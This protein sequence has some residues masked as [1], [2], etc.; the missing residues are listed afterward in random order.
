MEKKLLKREMIYYSNGIDD[1]GDEYAGKTGIEEYTYACPCGN[2][3]I[4]EEHDDTPGY[5]NHCVWILCKSCRE[6]YDIDKSEGVRNWKIFRKTTELITLGE[7]VEEL[8]DAIVIIP[9]LQRNYKWGVGNEEKSENGESEATAL[10][11]LEDIKN[12]KQNGRNEYTIGMV[13]LYR[14]GNKI[15][16]IDG[17]QRLITLSIL[18]KALGCYD[19]FLHIKFE[20]DENWE[21][22]SFLE[23]GQ[24]SDNVD[25]RHMQAVYEAFAQKLKTSESAGGNEDLCEW[26]LSH[27]KFM[28]RYTENEPLQEF[29]DLNENK[30]AFSPTD[31]DRAYQI[32]YQAEKKTIL[33]SMIIEEH[34]AIEK[35]LYTNENIFELIKKNYENPRSRMDLIFSPHIKDGSLSKYYENIDMSDDRDKKYTECYEYLKYCHKIFED[36]DRQLEIKDGARLNVNVYNSVMLYEVCSNSKFFKLII[37]D[38]NNID[39]MTFERKV[40]EEYKKGMSA[41][42]KKRKN[43]F[44]QSQ[45]FSGVENFENMQSQL[46]SEVENFEKKEKVPVRYQEAVNYIT[47]AISQIYES[48]VRE[49]EDII[50]AGNNFCETKKSEDC[51]NTKKVEAGTNTVDERNTSELNG[52]KSFQEILEMPEIKEII[53][54]TIQRDYT[55]GSD[56]AG[57]MRLLFAISESYISDCIGDKDSDRYENGTALRIAHYNLSKGKFWKEI[58]TL[59]V[60]NKKPFEAFEIQYELFEFAANESIYDPKYGGDWRERKSKL[61][62]KLLEWEKPTEISDFSEVKNGSYFATDTKNEFPFSA[63]LGH[64]ENGKFYL[65]DG[66]QRIVTLVY[67]CAYLI[68]QEY[69]KAKTEEIRRKYDR[70]IDI[71]SKFRFESRKDANDMLQSLLNNKKP[72]TIGDESFKSYVT[73]HSTYSIYTL[74]ETYENYQN[75]YGNKIM[76]FNLDYLMKKVIFE[77]VIVK[78]ASLVDQMY[79]DLNTKNV[80]LEP[81][82]T[83]KAE[84]VYILSQRFPAQYEEYWKYQLD[85]RFLDQCYEKADG[86]NKKLCEEAEKLEINIICWCFKMACMERKIFI[87]AVE[88]RAKRLQWMGESSAKDVIELVGKLLNEKIKDIIEKIKDKNILDKDKKY[89]DVKKFLMAEFDL[90]YDLRYS[91]ELL[92]K[93]NPYKFARNKKSG[94]VRIYNLEKEN[95]KKYASYWTRLAMYYQQP[96]T[97]TDIVRFLLQKYRTYWDEGYLQAEL[98]DS[99]ERRLNEENKN[100]KENVKITTDYYSS[101][102]L[103]EVGGITWIELIYITKLNEML[104]GTQYELV[105]RWEDEEDTKNKIFSSEEKMLAKKHA[106]GDYDLWCYIEERVKTYK[107][108]KASI[109]IAITEGTQIA[110]KV[111]EVIPDEVLL[112]ACINS[113]CCEKIEEDLNISVSYKENP[114]IIEAVR[115]YILENIPDNVIRKIKRDY[116]VGNNKDGQFVVYRTIAARGEEDS[117]CEKKEKLEIGCIDIV[118]ADMPEKFV[119]KLR[120]EKNILENNCLLYWNLYKTEQLDKESYGNYLKKR[121]IYKKTLGLISEKEKHDLKKMYEEVTGYSADE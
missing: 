51:E 87:G 102:Y 19:T 74:L 32:K 75:G 3:T 14:V 28:C 23:F 29:L 2:G 41:Y 66:Q 64:L 17:Q 76:S 85:N 103:K 31:Y 93:P 78:E 18:M 44:M 79:M 113:Q 22:E 107:E 88:D 121:D 26:M 115:K 97:D 9:L 11:L 35:Y 39:S 81:Y 120:T 86:W 100:E 63:I 83:Y 24:K 12:A 90:W 50:E 46:F 116:W 52:R 92:L 119:E 91:S 61:Y 40:W 71:L 117:S 96:K 48:K 58:T 20:R 43:A 89:V 106:Y 27:L 59:P 15:Q 110:F 33:P 95:A 47:D 57:T 70:Y 94:Y 21:R 65:Y 69:E 114:A 62:K 55:L 111:A 7:F 82:E 84:L 108:K 10:K 37:D 109:N 98:A 56:K 42:E 60:N 67:L 34:N 13:T 6:K 101:D 1:E 53:V 30:T 112:R 77:F 16:V 99:V 36:M 80:P 4:V 54:P 38:A 25:V 49:T 45:L 68:N 118:I 5:R 72:I 104:S 105:K 8:K 73:D